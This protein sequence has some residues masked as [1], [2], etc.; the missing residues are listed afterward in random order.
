M[1]YG[2]CI[3]DLLRINE[4]D[5][6]AVNG[7]LSKLSIYIDATK[8][9]ESVHQLHEPI[10]ASII[11]FNF[12]WIT[13]DQ[14]PQYGN[15][16]KLLERFV[17]SA[18]LQQSKGGLLLIGLTTHSQYRYQYAIE[19]LINFANTQGYPEH[20]KESI[21][22][23]DDTRNLSFLRDCINHGYRHFSE[24]PNAVGTHRRFVVDG[25]ELHVFVKGAYSRTDL[26]I[27][28]CKIVNRR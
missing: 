7:L 19:G 17:E 1:R 3:I 24:N 8:I 13:L 18:A 12:P 4:D 2:N 23:A 28:G 22:E 26:S 5:P 11:F 10:D 15:N 25:S 20:H 9:S 6:S 16:A 21:G 27:F 14:R